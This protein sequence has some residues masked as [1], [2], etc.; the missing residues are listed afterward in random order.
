LPSHGTIEGK[1]VELAF[2]RGSKLGFKAYTSCD[3]RYV[4]ID[5]E[6]IDTMYVGEKL[7]ELDA[8]K[9]KRAEGQPAARPVSK[10]AR[11]AL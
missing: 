8:S 10:P 3:N 11:S 5:Q 7:K 6:K 4:V 1:V 9:F 2:R